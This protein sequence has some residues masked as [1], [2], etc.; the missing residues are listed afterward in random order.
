MQEQPQN[1][2]RTRRSTRSTGNSRIQTARRPAI[3]C[4]RAACVGCYNVCWCV[5]TESAAPPIRDPDL[6]N[7][8]LS[9]L[10]AV[11]KEGLMSLRPP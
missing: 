7:P 9:V 4:H 1:A 6:M 2:R 10:N 11:W 3:D 8:F 5:P